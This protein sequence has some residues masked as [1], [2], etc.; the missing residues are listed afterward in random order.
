VGAKTGACGQETIVGLVHAELRG[1]G[2][3]G[4]SFCSVD[5]ALAWPRAESEEGG[6]GLEGPHGRMAAWSPGAP[7]RKVLLAYP[8]GRAR[9]IAATFS[10]GPRGS[11]QR[12]AASEGGS[13]A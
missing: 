4:N 13:M 1:H 6:E 10:R 7:W 2:G 11:E 8:R 3:G 5:G 12:A 9:F